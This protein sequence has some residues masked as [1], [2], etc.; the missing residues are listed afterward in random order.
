MARPGSGNDEVSL[1]I[2]MAISM[3]PGLKG[4]IVYEGSTT[5][6]I[7]NRMATDNLAKQI[8][9]SWTY[10]I[11]ANSEQIFLQFAAQGQS[12]FNASGDSDAY[13]GA[14]STP[15]DDPNITIVGGTTLT[16]S[17]AGGAW[18]S[19]TVWNW[20]GGTGSSGGI[21]TLYAIPS[22]QQGINMTA[23]QGSTTMRNIPDVALTADNV[24]V[25]YGNGQARR[26]WRHQLR[27]AVVG[28]FYRARQSTGPDQWRA[29]HRVYQS[30]RLWHGQ[31]IKRLELYL[32][33]SRHHHRKQ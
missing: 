18:A 9:A 25:I 15:A 1:D 17:G 5:D 30:R 4:V 31:R 27:H 32:A 12:F 11:D 19:E 23:N 26:L 29:D 21:S 20:G 3:A 33:F 2:E 10:P 24:Y 7:L 22:W 13:A 28:G 16:T 6:D 14:I 8:G